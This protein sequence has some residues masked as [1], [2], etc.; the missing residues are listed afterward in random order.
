MC[1][2]L[3]VG[4][5]KGLGGWGPRSREARGIS[6]DDRGWGVRGAGL[7][8]HYEDLASSGLEGLFLE[9]EHGLEL[10]GKDSSDRQE[11]GLG[12]RQRGG[13]DLA[14]GHM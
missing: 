14:S 2:P 10:Y 5:R 13:S 11:V 9:K 8:D 3:H 4:A 6:P 1:A 7:A 12:E